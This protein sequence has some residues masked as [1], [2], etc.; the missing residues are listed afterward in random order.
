M[1]EA[2]KADMVDEL[3]ETYEADELDG[4]DEATRGVVDSF[5]EW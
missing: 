2:E 5:M 3:N 1:G 4:V